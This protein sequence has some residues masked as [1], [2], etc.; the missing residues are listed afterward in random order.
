MAWEAALL[1]TLEREW[2]V[3]AAHRRLLDA[4]GAALMATC[5]AHLL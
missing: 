1:A 4:Q 3:L 2:A 5:C